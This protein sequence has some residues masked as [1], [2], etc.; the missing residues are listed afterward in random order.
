MEYSK[1]E[2]AR[3]QLER[4][5]DLFFKEKDYI[6]IITLAGASEEI[7]RKMLEQKKEVSSMEKVKEW[8]VENHPDSEIHENFY[9]HANQTRNAL[10]HY[11]NPNESSE[12]IDEDTAIY[13]ICRAVMNYGRAHKS[14]TT[15]MNTYILWWKKHNS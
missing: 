14:L 2:I 7:T 11:D 9:K 5:I 8:M 13:W 4:A 6:S 15:P 12:T 1:S 3:I 10:K